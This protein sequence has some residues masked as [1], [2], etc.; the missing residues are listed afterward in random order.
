[1]SVFY[2]LN[3]NDQD[4]RRYSANVVSSTISIF[5]AV[6]MFEAVNGFCEEKLGMDDWDA[7]HQ[8]GFDFAHMVL[9][10]TLMQCALAKTSGAMLTVEQKE[11]AHLEL[12]EL[13]MKCYATLLAHMTGFAAINAFAQLQQTEFFSSHS[14]V[15]FLVVPIAM[16]TMYGLQRATD[17]VRERIALGDGKK[18]EFETLWDDETEEAENEVFGLALSFTATQAIRFL[19]GG[20]LPDI[21]GGEEKEQLLGHDLSQKM[22]LF[23]FAVLFAVATFFSV[24]TKPEETHDHL[25]HLADK[26]VE[27]SATLEPLLRPADKNEM[28]ADGDAVGRLLGENLTKE[29]RF[30]LLDMVGSEDVL[31][32]LWDA[33]SVAASMTMAWCF[34]FSGRWF[35]SGTPEILYDDTEAHSDMMMLTL[36]QALVLSSLSFSLIRV[37]DMIEDRHR[38][39]AQ[40]KNVEE[41]IEQIIK[42]LGILVGFAWEQCF[43]TSVA[44]ISSR[45]PNPR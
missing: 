24:Y 15:A 8:F 20:A 34:F 4:M 19:V 44:A 26:V 29:N 7:I 17:T 33:I 35:L 22:I 27:E 38:S 41:G 32:R 3:H 39:S 42:A 11:D 25:Q 2:L 12:M 1:M 21:E 37:L 43:D 18:D 30:K 5:C 23:S 28:G 9:W 10:F 36:L 40:S 16:V 14:L 6:L 45:L 13:D 31:D